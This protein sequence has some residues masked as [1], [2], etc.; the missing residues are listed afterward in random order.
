MSEQIPPCIGIDFG[1]TNSKMAWYNHRISQAEVLKNKEGEER[2]PSVVY[3]GKKETLV[4]KPVENLLDDI[5]YLGDQLDEEFQRVIWSIKRHLISPPTISLP[6]GKDVRPTQ[7]A[8]EI[9]AKLKRDAEDLHFHEKVERAVITFPAQFN[10]KQQDKIREAAKEAGFVE[11]DLLEEPEAA[12]LAFGQMAQKVGQGLLVYDLG[13]G[14]FDLAFVVRDDD[15]QYRVAIETNG[16]PRCGGDDFDQAL[17]NYW[18]R[19][20]REKLRRPINNVE[21]ENDPHFL[22]ECRQRKENLSIRD[23]CEFSSFLSGGVIFKMKIDRPTFEGLIRNTIDR[24]VRLTKTMLNE[25]QEN[26]HK[27]DTIVLIGGSSRIPLIE[28]MLSETLAVSPTKWQNQDV[29]V[30][31][32]AAYRAWHKWGPKPKV[33]RRLTQDTPVGPKFGTTT[34]S[35]SQLTSQ[36]TGAAERYRLAVEMAWADRNLQ[37]EEV[38]MLRTLAKQ[39]QLSKSDA[40]K[41]EIAVMGKTK[42]KLLE[43][44]PRNPAPPTTDKRAIDEV[45]LPVLRAFPQRDFYVESEIPPKKLAKAIKACNVPNNERILGLIDCTVLGSAKNCLLLGRDG[46]YYR[47][48]S[49]P[50]MIKYSDFRLCTFE[51]VLLSRQISVGGGRRIYLGGSNASPKKLCE[52][53]NALKLTIYSRYL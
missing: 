35:T 12:A 20:A 31:L 14:T 7:V 2:T 3:F 19:E 9:L 23:Q 36:P 25:A 11:V 49:G 42:E 41:L 50:N 26:G 34:K 32:G 21:G 46:I 47:S 39:L 1:T 27:V 28:K 38:E 40:E 15:G 22:R 29:A 5:Q 37:R 13:G 51:T 33:P 30:A 24:T 53:L 18:D 8:T 17:Y 16:D 48:A 44:T 4:G 10:S 43:T 52:M 45:I 6:G